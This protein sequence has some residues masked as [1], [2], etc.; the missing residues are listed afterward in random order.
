MQVEG[1]LVVR[2]VPGARVSVGKLSV[3]NSGWEWR[4]LQPDD[5]TAKEE[6]KMRCVRVWGSGSLGQGLRSSLQG[7]VCA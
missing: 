1:A 5:A 3:R 4:P 7:L 6:E 2:A